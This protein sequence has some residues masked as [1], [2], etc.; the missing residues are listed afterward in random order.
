[1]YLSIGHRNR[2]KIKHELNIKYKK[3]NYEDN[4]VT[5]GFVRIM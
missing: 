4:Y 2:S 3:I 1:M 5:H